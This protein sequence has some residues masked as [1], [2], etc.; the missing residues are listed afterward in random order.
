MF[1]LR[2][3]GDPL[4]AA[5]DARAAIREANGDAN[6]SHVST[7]ESLIAEDQTER[8][9]QTWLIGVFS[10]LSLGLAALGVFAVMHFAVI[11]KTRSGFGSRWVREART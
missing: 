1:L 9:F 5:G 11:A 3:A 8:R 7:V 2:T 10:T 6:I 4:R